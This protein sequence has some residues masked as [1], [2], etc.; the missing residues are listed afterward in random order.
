MTNFLENA[1]ITDKRET[2]MPSLSPSKATKEDSMSISSVYTEKPKRICKHEGCDRPLKS[3]GYCGKHAMRYYFGKDMDYTSVRDPRPAIID[4]NI[5]RLPL[6][7]DAKDG[8]SIID[9]EDAYLDVYKWSLTKRG[10]VA[11]GKGALLHHA[12]MGKPEKGYFVDHINR[13][14]LDNRRSNL[15]F[16][17]MSQ[18]NQNISKQKNNTSGHRGVHW[19]KDTSKWSAEIKVNYKKIVLGC[20]ENID[21]AAKA[22]NKAAVKYFGEFAVLNEVAE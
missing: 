19:R 8:H 22:Y 10:Y 14:R 20:Y 4:G 18:N 1:I 11:R 9:V 12:I 21:D 15:R 17:T 13:D 7:I 5:A 2:K 3:Y 16:V 6:G